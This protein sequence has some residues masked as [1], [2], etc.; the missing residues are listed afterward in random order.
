MS[1]FGRLLKELR[2]QKNMSLRDLAEKTGVS[3][4][5]IGSMEKGRYKPSR[6]TVIQLA[7]FLN[8]DVDDLLVSAGFA[9]TKIID[10]TPSKSDT[11]PLEK[12]FL[13]WIKNSIGGA[14]FYDFDSAPEERKEQL[15]KDL[16]YMWEREKDGTKKIEPKKK[17]ED[18]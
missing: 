12:E 17:L 16:R 14:F 1:D 7:K 10:I 2:L 8:C 11:A 13:E 5:F 18:F 3:Y 4:S 6:D 9:P 15:M